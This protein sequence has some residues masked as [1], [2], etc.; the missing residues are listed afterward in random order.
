M[1]YGRPV[2]AVNIRNG[3]ALK[4]DKAIQITKAVFGEGVKSEEKLGKG[5]YRQYGK[6]EDGFN[7]SSCQFALHYFFKDQSTFQNFMRNVAECTKI[8]KCMV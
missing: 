6:G 2:L 5:V 1:R 8:Q 3:N 4:S 7:V